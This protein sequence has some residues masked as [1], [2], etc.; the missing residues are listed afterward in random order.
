[1]EPVDGRRLRRALNIDAVVGAAVEFLHEGRYSFSAQDVADRAGVSLRSVFRYHPT[2]DALIA[3]AGEEYVAR[4]AADLVYAPRVGVDHPLEERVADLVAHCAAFY[5]RCQGFSR[6][7]VRRAYTDPYYAEI[8]AENRRAGA[9]SIELV[10]GPELAALP[11][12]Q[13]RDAVAD[14]HSALLF[15]TWDNLV[16]FHG[17]D[18]ADAASLVRRRLLTALVP[19]PSDASA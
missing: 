3:A 12:D 5:E 1:M 14:A 9:E 19:V 4:H 17:L 6:V 8:V 2:M 18:L 10:F 13:R 7:A 11:A 15:A 16:A